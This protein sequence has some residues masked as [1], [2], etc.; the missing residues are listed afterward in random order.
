MLTKE[1]FYATYLSSGDERFPYMLLDRMRSDC[2]YCIANG[3]N[4]R[5]LWATNDPVAH[6][7]YM[8][9]IMDF[10]PEKPEWLTA[11]QIDEFEQLMLEKVS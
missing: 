4:Y 3:F 5:H 11:E 6:I 10:L 1:E 2:A 7:T 9:Y 8:R